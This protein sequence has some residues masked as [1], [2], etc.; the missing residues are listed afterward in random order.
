MRKYIL[1]FILTISVIWPVTG[2]VDR[3]VP[4][5]PGPAPVIKIAEY[6]SFTLP[7]G[8]QVFVVENH[9]IPRV[10]Y[11]L[12]FDHDPV[13]E[14]KDA[15]YVSMT[16]DLL[17]TA[18]ATRTKDQIDE[19]IDF[20]GASLST[21]A[22]SVYASSLKKHN[23][24]LLDVFS[25]VVLNARFKQDELDKLKTQYKSG[26]AASKDDAN[27]ISSRV[28]DV[29]VYGKD[30]PYGE[31]ETDASIDNIDLDMCKNY[32]TNYLRPNDAFLAIVGDITLKEAKK[33][34][35]EY[36]SKWEKGPVP[37]QTFNLPKPP[38]STKVAIVD[39]PSAVQSVITVSYPVQL[40]IG[41][42]D[43]IPAK[44][45]NTVLGG[46]TYRLFDNLR[47]KHG[48]TYGS[49][50]SLNGDKLIGKF[51][52]FANVS[53]AVTDSSIYQILYEMKRLDTEKVPDKELERVKNNMS[54][55][56]ALSLERP[57]TVASFA[58]N[59][60]RYNLPKNY[61]SNY[62]KNLSA[63]TPDQV[64]A[65]AKK[66][67]LPQHSNILVVGK[68]DEVAEKI[69]HFSKDNSITYYD[70]YGNPYNPSAKA[71][72]VPAGMTAQKVIDQY[73]DAIGGE[74]NLK[75][76]K[77]IT[78]KLSM[79]MQGMSMNQVIYK[80]VPDKYAMEMS[81]NGNTI[82]KIVFDGTSGKTSGMQ[83]NADLTEDQIAN[84]KYNNIPIV[85][86]I[87][88]SD[89]GYKLEL[90]GMEE[91]DGQKAYN[92]MVTTP[93]G[94]QQQEYYSLDTGLKLR[95]VSTMS[96]PQ[97]E[98]TQTVDYSNYKEVD[99]VKFPFALKQSV[100]PRSFDLKV[101]SITVNSD[102]PDDTF[103]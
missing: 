3:S 21:S 64:L 45:T 15:G 28:T 63:V 89:E 96:T 31:V 71:Q 90:K 35:P 10:S 46:G 92:I 65:I 68:A 51:M 42:P 33:I 87:Q 25:D 36:F 95:T 41:S 37:S 52:A 18:T 32:Y 61:Y 39:R 67:I 80:K 53:N 48:Y 84:L 19:A 12:V 79:E 24:E 11:S 70:I 17:G 100:G 66:Y 9:K 76:I 77:D 73:I 93:D 34:I 23:E 55:N 5:P 86:D 2:Q 27:A 44:V 69:K 57:Q 60:A 47:E 13:S 50:S 54:G 40:E 78:V 75:K 7:N 26:L 49:Y 43:Y 29:L 85:P 82:Q 38:E 58:L 14:G 83:G 101:D 103:K 6:E 98:I 4:P 56:F 81:M 91:V 88:Y 99:G 59:T 30:F 20:I 62:L 74:K 97:G 1:L 8:L 102:L 94:N 22:N 16:G 72:A